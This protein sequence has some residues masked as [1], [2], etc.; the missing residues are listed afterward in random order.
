MCGRRE[1]FRA[2]NY[3][4]KGTRA[5]LFGLLSVLNIFNQFQLCGCDGT[6]FANGDLNRVPLP[7][8]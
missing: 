4:L 8:A 3:R 7:F 2:D 5:E 1:G 6:V